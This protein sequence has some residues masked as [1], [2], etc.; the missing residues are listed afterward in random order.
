[1][2]LF[3]RFKS[4]QSNSKIAASVDE[5]EKQYYQPDDY[6][7][8]IAFEGSSFEREVIPFEERKK[9]SYTSNGGLYVPEI[10]LLQY[11]EYGNYPH[12]SNGYPGLW[13]YQYGIRDV[14]AALKQLE[15]RGFICFGSASA[16]LK[17]LK[18]SELKELLVEKNC[19]ASGKKADLIERISDNYSEQELIS[20]GVEPKYILTPLGEKEL[21]ENEYIPFMHSFHGTTIDN[22]EN[23]FNVWSINRTLK[24]IEPENWKDIIVEEYNRTHNGSSLLDTILRADAEYRIKSDLDKYVAFWENLW[25][26]GKL[27]IDIPLWIFK[28]SELYAE[29][30]RYDDALS[31]ANKVNQLY[32]NEY[33]DYAADLIKRIEK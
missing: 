19:S 28:L 27:D 11:C 5:S 21:Q 17:R 20:K 29:Q 6:Y 7:K 4:K 22:C 32:E 24:G 10:L 2:G 30:G 26:N 8:K 15:E 1:M 9:T 23:E 3:D 12:P 31:F 16:S 18:V 33:E 14:T 13:W 25:A